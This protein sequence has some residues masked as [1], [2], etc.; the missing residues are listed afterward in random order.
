MTITTRV[1]LYC[2]VGLKCTKG[3]ARTFE[4][5]HAGERIRQWAKARGWN[6]WGEKDAC[7]DCWKELH[8]ATGRKDEWDELTGPTDQDLHA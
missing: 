6:S 5:P 7:P 2:D 4:G 1:Q 8:S 3:I